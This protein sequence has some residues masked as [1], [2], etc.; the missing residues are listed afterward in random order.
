MTLID[1]VCP[2]SIPKI[3][4]TSEQIKADYRLWGTPAAGFL[5]AEVNI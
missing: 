1:R 3:S 2:I 5:F 4:I